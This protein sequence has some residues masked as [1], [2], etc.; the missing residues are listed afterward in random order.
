[1]QSK[2]YVSTWYVHEA[3]SKHPELSIVA[4]IINNLKSQVF[5][6]GIVVKDFECAQYAM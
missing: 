2:G 4:I 6:L 1:M 5:L 3:L